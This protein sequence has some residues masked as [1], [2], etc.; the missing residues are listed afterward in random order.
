MALIVSLIAAV[1]ERLPQVEFPVHVESSTSMQDMTTPV[2]FA[3]YLGLAAFPVAALL[4][5]VPTIVAMFL[6]RRDR[7]L[8]LNAAPPQYE[9]PDG[10]SPA[11]IVAAWRGESERGSPEVFAATLVDLA[12]RGWVTL[13]AGD[14]FVATPTSGGHGQ[15]RPWERSLMDALMPEGAPAV[16]ETYDPVQAEVWDGTYAA[17]VVAA[18]AS[19]R[20]N[21]D[22]GRPDQRWNGLTAVGYSAL[23]IGL[24]SIF[25]A[26]V[27]AAFLIPVGIGAVI[28]GSIARAITPRRQTHQSAVFLAKVEGFVRVLST[29]PAVARRDIAMAIG[30]PP[31]AIMATMLPFA[32]AFDLVNSWFGAFPDLTPADVASTGFGHLTITQVDGLVSSTQTSAQAATTAPDSPSRRPR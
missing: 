1:K 8:D 31:A 30:M 3:S 15:V 16:L 17:L 27:V 12:A 23:G 22:G 26:D 6:R 11:E 20:S 4:I 2:P 7:G 13:V 28:G 18:D 10:L 25:L 19:G 5:L 9:P 14:E 24:V 29:D 32:I 21:P